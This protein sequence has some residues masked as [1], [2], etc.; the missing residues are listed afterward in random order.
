MQQ[1]LLILLLVCSAYLIGAVPFSLIIGRL[2]GVDIRKKGSG[3]VGAVNVLRTAG[4]T[5]GILAFASDI[6]KGVAAVIVSHLLN[7]FHTDTILLLGACAAV[8]GHMFPVYLKGKGGKGVATGAGVMLALSPVVILSSIAVYFI[9]LFSSHRTSSVGSISGALS[10]PL[11]L[12]LYYFCFPKL[13][14]VFFTVDYLWF[15]AAAVFIILLVVIK[16]VPNIKRLIRG[17]E[18]RFGNT[19]K[20]DPE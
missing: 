5:A 17:N 8:I 19:D 13:Y 7:P 20:K 15:L 18:N 2:W 3:N 9:G 12:T 14:S 16:H 6:G 11:F 1:A 10:F 4:K